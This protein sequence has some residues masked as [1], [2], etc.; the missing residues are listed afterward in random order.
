MTIVSTSRPT[1][2]LPGERAKLI[3]L[4]SDMR[5]DKTHVERFIRHLVTIRDEKLYRADHKTFEVYCQERWGISRQH[6][7]RQI[8]F[9]RTVDAI[10]AGEIGTNGSKISP[11]NE[12]V[13]RPMMGLPDETRRE[14]W[15]E[16]VA[17]SG[18]KPT[19]EHVAKAVAKVTGDPDTDKAI[20]D[21]IIPPG[22]QIWITEP[23]GTKVESYRAPRPENTESPD[24]VYAVCP[25]CG[26]TGKIEGLR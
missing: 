6:A 4:E 11:P 10:E 18:G 22:A 5:I 25:Q 1:S 17:D 16:A 20:A 26:G 8:E 12:H 13:A 3:R 2:L 14:A 19:R 9:F 15:K 23:D 7:N 21:G 24:H